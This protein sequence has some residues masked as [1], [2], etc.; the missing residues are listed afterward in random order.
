VKKINFVVATKDQP[1]DLHRILEGRAAHSHL[2]DIVIIADSSGL[3]V[4]REAVE[5]AS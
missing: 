4:S 1:D 5:V 2:P 3:K